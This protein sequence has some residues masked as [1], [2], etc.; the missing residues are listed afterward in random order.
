MKNYN[1][2]KIVFSLF[3]LLFVYTDAGANEFILGVPVLKQHGNISCWAACT[4]MMML[5]YDVVKDDEKDEKEKEFDIRR[6]AF[7]TPD[8]EPAP[9]LRNERT[10]IADLKARLMVTSGNYHGTVDVDI[11]T[12]DFVKSILDQRVPIVAGRY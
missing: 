7:N 6:L 3:A 10:P 4:Q 11:F 5:Y 2:S 8:T 9:N 12:P 1:S